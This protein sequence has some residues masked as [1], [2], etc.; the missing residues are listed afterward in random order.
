MTELLEY[1]GLNIP[2]GTY[3]IDKE[4]NIYSLQR[5]VS[6]GK[7][8]ERL[9]P[10][11]KMKQKL[12]TDGYYQIQLQID[13]KTKWVRTHRLIANTFIDNPYKYNYI[14]HIDGNKLNNNVLN[15]EW[16]TNVENVLHAH[17]NSL[18]ENSKYTQ[19]K[20]GHIPWNKKKV[21]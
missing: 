18:M 2:K 8:G 19:F 13:T 10:F 7:R 4:G 3:A 15:L 14:N 6:K 21:S 20:K 1:N 17:A 12:G 5:L 16:C 9:L 11:R